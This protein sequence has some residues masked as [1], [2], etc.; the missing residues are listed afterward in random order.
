MK[1]TLCADLTGPHAVTP[2]VGFK[3]LLVVVAVDKEGKKLPLCRGLQTK[4][5]QEVSIALD[6][7]IKEIRVLDPSVEFVRFHTDAGNEFLN[8]DVEKVLKDLQAL[9]DPHRRT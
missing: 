8:A 1:L 4:R 7:V 9:S 3:Y 6:S 5:G 2:G